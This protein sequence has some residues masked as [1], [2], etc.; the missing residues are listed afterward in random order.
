M[1]LP[2]RTKVVATLGPS[3]SNE[4]AITELIE[5]GVN[6]FRL[7]CSH[8]NHETLTSNTKAI[9]KI[10]KRM[11][12][13]IGILGD[14][15]GPKIRVGQLKEPIPLKKGQAIIITTKRGYIGAPPAEKETARV[16]TGY[17]NLA[18]DVKAGETILLDDGNL[19][20]KVVSVEGPEVH[21]KVVHGGL[22]KQNKGIN[23]PGSK[24]SADALTA[25]DREDLAHLITLDVDFVALSFVRTADDVKLLTRLLDE[26]GSQAKVISKLERPEVVDHLDAIIEASYGVMVARGDM[27]VELGPEIVPGLQKR[28]IKQSIAACKP[29]ITATHGHADVGVDDRKPT[30]HSG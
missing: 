21:C 26:A 23:L 9:R 2:N 5:A 19:E 29:V 28:I 24:V 11:G 16:G 14:L 30:P 17:E 6:V 13:P 15:Q 25:K 22:L 18:K 7:N 10:A 27:G 12:E 3:T 1:K 20:L 8:A 4:K